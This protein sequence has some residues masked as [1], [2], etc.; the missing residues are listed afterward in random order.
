M[1][2][3]T[4]KNKTKKGKNRGIPKTQLGFSLD[5]K[6]ELKAV[7]HVLRSVIFQL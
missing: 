1:V 5:Q 2:V 6:C 7:G 3:E 4:T